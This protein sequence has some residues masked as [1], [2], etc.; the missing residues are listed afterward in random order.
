MP[1]SRESS[2]RTWCGNCWRNIARTRGTPQRAF[3]T[4]EDEARLR[5]TPPS[6]TLCGDFEQTASFFVAGGA[7]AIVVFAIVVAVGAGRDAGQTDQLPPAE[8]GPGRAE[9]F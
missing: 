2:R 5:P 9:L 6:S 4:G 3:P 7:A 1:S 8:G